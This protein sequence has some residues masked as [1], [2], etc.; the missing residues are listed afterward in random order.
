M[1]EVF[2]KLCSSDHHITG[3]DVV[4]SHFVS[5]STEVVPN[6]CKAHNEAIVVYTSSIDW[7]HQFHA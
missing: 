7:I 5:K 6:F 2:G 3:F 4:G 1:F